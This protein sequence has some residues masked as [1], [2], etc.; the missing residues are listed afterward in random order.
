MSMLQRGLNSLKSSMTPQLFSR[1]RQSAQLSKNPLRN[2]SF[3][4]PVPHNA[5][6]PF[7][8]EGARLP[9][10][11]KPCIALPSMKNFEIPTSVRF[12]INDSMKEGPLSPEQIEYFKKEY[13]FEIQAVNQCNNI[14]LVDPIELTVPESLRVD[15][16][17][18]KTTRLENGETPF[19]I[20]IDFLKENKLITE[21][22]FWCGPKDMPELD[23]NSYVDILSNRLAD[24]SDP[25]VLNLAHWEP[26]LV[27]D[28]LI[29]NFLSH[30]GNHPDRIYLANLGMWAGSLDL[31]GDGNSKSVVFVEYS[32]FPHRRN[33]FY[34][35]LLVC[36]SSGV[37]PIMLQNRPDRP[38]VF[39]G[40]ADLIKLYCPNLKGGEPHVYSITQN[41]SR[42]NPDTCDFLLNVL[43][44]KLARQQEHENTDL[45]DWSTYRNIELKVKDEYK[46]RFYHLDL[47]VH[48]KYSESGFVDIFVAEDAYTEDSLYV[49]K[50]LVNSNERMRWHTVPIEEALSKQSVNSIFFDKGLYDAKDLMILTG[51]GTYLENMAE[52]MGVATF[53][54]RRDLYKLNPTLKVSSKDIVEKVPE[55]PGGGNKRCK[56]MS[57]SVQIKPRDPEIIG[58]PDEVVKKISPEELRQMNGQLADKYGW[59]FRYTDEMIDDLKEIISRTG[60]DFCKY[61]PLGAYKRPSTIPQR[62]VPQ[63]GAWLNTQIK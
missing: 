38:M 34:R 24:F 41:S 32:R 50:K 7:V 48:L 51:E 1:S 27:K 30:V 45:S 35:D 47:G 42:T 12:R 22:G 13:P 39:E 63:K 2:V 23:K 28:I 16:W 21:D 4:R 31:F 59:V 26:A 49:L 62:M 9:A 8:R 55:E 29:G 15:D 14:M 10:N 46:E 11:Q 25:K 61:Y 17:V 57:M 56:M 43:K 18:L 44:V 40:M 37:L 58:L 54:D 3:Y 60:G 52:K 53:K 5:K 33:E 6:G 19:S 36:M 20:Y